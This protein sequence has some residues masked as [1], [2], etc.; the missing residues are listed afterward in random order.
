MK[1]L[2]LKS[3]VSRDYYHFDAVSSE[4]STTNYTVT[5]CYDRKE[6]VFDWVLN[7]RKAFFVGKNVGILVVRSSDGRHFGFAGFQFQKLGE[8]LVLRIEEWVDTVNGL[9]EICEKYGAREVDF[10]D[11]HLRWVGFVK[12]V[13]A[14]DFSQI[15]IDF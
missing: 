15:G 13:N 12:R 7:A 11:F 10:S 6:K 14:L 9:N 4:N 1:N 8:G 2:Q 5:L 3:L